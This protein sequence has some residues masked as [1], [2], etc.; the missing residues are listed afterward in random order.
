VGLRVFDFPKP[1]ATPQAKSADTL[2]PSPAPSQLNTIV[3]P[4]QEEGFERVFLPS[5]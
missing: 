3:V 4:A 2:R 5:A 1:V